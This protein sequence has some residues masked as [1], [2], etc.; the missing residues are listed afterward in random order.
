MDDDD[1]V[2]IIIGLGTL[3]HVTHDSFKMQQRHMITVTKKKNISSMWIGHKE[4][5]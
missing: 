3:L 4:M 1:D 2:V 5:I